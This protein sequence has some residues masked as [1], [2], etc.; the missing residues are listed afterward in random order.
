[1]NVMCKN[2]WLP[3]IFASTETNL[4]LQ[5]FH[6]LLDY[7]SSAWLIAPSDHWSISTNDL[8]LVSY[9]HLK[10]K[11][12]TTDKAR[13]WLLPACFESYCCHE[14]SASGVRMFDSKTW[15]VHTAW[16][17]EHETAVNGLMCDAEINGLDLILFWALNEQQARQLRRVRKYILSQTASGAERVSWHW[18]TALASACCSEVYWYWIHI[19]TQ[20]CDGCTHWSAASASSKKSCRTTLTAQTFVTRL[21]TNDSSFILWCS[22]HR[23]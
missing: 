10:P 9:P 7:A 14:R 19:S 12:T 23:T 16:S 22:C 11:V 4:R 15:N 17:A 8:L 2:Q 5:I 6:F 13:Y 21:R 1:M 18:R 20:N 3:T